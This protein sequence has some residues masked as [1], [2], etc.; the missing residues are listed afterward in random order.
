VT[1]DEVKSQK[2]RMPRGP[3]DAGWTN[4]KRQASN[5][6]CC[7]GCLVRGSGVVCTSG[8]RAPRPSPLHAERVS[9]GSGVVCAR[10]AA[11]GTTALQG[12]GPLQ[13]DHEGHEGHE[14]AKEVRVTSDEVKSQKCRNS[15]DRDEI[16]AHK[17]AKAQRRGIM[18]Q[19]E[20]T[21]AGSPRR[22]R[23]A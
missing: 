3:A 7:V 19:R 9:R 15:E 5:V 13:V 17:A 12:H 8:T 2:C 1:S 23:R 11:V 16:V 21:A 14:G 10:E 22:T 20:W 4:V 6:T 18:Q